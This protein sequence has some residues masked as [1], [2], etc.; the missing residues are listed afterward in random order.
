VLLYGAAVA[1]V[2]A[3]GGVVELGFKAALGGAIPARLLATSLIWWRVYTFY[4]Y[5]LVGAFAAG[6]TVM[7]ALRRGTEPFDYENETDEVRAPGA[8]GRGA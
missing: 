8:E 5:L 2:P 7:N 4:I 3:G 6:R 1:P